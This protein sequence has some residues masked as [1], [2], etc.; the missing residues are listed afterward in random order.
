MF[1][2]HITEP[3]H[4]TS[5]SIVACKL[6]TEFQRRSQD[7]FHAQHYHI[8]LLLRTMNDVTIDPLLVYLTL[9]IVS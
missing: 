2:S 3:F 8:S 5:L 1:S 9:N 6:D 7:E 4:Y